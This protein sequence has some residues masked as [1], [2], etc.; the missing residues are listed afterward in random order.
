MV[1]ILPPGRKRGLHQ[2]VGSRARKVLGPRQV[3]AEGAGRKTAG[4]EVGTRAQGGMYR[5]GP[6]RVQ[7]A[8]GKVLKE[9]AGRPMLAHLIDRLK[10]CAAFDRIVVAT[11][12]NRRDDPIAGLAGEAG[13][14][15]FRGDEEDVLS[16]YA[17][18]AAQA[19]AGV[20]VRVTGDCPLIDPVT[21]ENTVRYF[22]SGAYDYAA[23]GVGSGLPRGLDTEVFTRAAL[24]EAHQLAADRPSREH[25]TYYIYHHPERFR[26]AP[27]YEA[28]P[29]LQRSHYRLCVDEEDDFRLISEIYRRLYRPGLII[30]IREVV[31]L[32]DREPAL[33][34]LNSGVVQ[35]TV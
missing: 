15:V 20:V 17:G 24:E 14:E 5:A 12:V 29:E 32:L 26:L 21:S 27:P 30:D 23:A 7:P 35:K 10:A 31:D 33:A 1:R 6:H 34:A 22:L 4:I 16:R 13:V 11:T 19:D 18:A 9:L 2:E 25:V 3:P 28:P 8:L